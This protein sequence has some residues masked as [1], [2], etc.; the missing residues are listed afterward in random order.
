MVYQ[1]LIFKFLLAPRAGKKAS[2]VRSLL[3]LY[4]AS[5][6]QSCFLEDHGFPLAKI[7]Y[8]SVVPGYFI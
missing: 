1:T 4:Q 7:Y 2:R 3:D 6:S 5:I 8:Q